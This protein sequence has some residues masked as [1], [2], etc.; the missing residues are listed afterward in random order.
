MPGAGEGRT[1]L[2][3]CL[4]DVARPRNQSGTLLAERAKAR[5]E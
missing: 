4:V 1:R 5:L 2:V 3:V